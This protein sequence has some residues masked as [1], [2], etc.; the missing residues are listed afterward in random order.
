ML[1]IHGQTIIET[2]H[3]TL[4]FG[5]FFA[6][7][8]RFIAFIDEK[9]FRNRRLAIFLFVLSLVLYATGRFPVII[10]YVYVRSVDRKKK[11]NDV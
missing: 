1:L 8:P 3:S 9:D 5:D 6:F 10:W 7:H 4:M 11:A 2:M